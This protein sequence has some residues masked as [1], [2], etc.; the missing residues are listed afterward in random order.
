[1]GALKAG[2]GKWRH[3]SSQDFEKT[4]GPSVITGL[5]RNQLSDI[6]EAEQ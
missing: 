3:G 1:M 4:V 2:W 6:G 5:R